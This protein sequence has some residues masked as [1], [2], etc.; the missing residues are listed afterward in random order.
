MRKGIRDEFAHD[1][2]LVVDE[3]H[4]GGSDPECVRLTNAGQA[5]QDVLHEEN[6]RA[7][8]S[9]LPSEQDRA[10]ATGARRRRN[11]GPP[12]RYELGERALAAVQQ[13]G[14]TTDPAAIQKLA[15]AEELLPVL[16]GLLRQLV[17]SDVAETLRSSG[18]CCSRERA[19]TQFRQLPT[20][21]VRS[22]SSGNGPHRVRCDR[23]ASV[24]DAPSIGTA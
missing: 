20:P 9:I 17:L 23:H 11:D 19:W 21:V 22:A 8:A 1:V 5:R 6:E 24:L 7:S 4:L 3:P 18:K 13:D 15:R 12:V 2:R 14:G 10:L 16:L